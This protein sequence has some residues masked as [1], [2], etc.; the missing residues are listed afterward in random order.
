MPRLRSL[1][2]RDELL[3]PLE[4]KKFTYAKCRSHIAVERDT[5]VRSRVCMCVHERTRIM[6]YVAPRI[7]GGAGVEEVGECTIL[8]VDLT[9]SRPRLA[10]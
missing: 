1:L 5:V 9:Q 8:E 7:W 3:H 2:G 10:N 6:L 4:V